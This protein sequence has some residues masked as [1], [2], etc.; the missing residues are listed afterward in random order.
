MS[1][2]SRTR[3]SNTCRALGPPPPLPEGGGWGVGGVGCSARLGGDSSLRMH[4]PAAEVRG[5][6]P[7]ASVPCTPSSPSEPPPHR[8]DQPVVPPRDQDVRDLHRF[9]E[10]LPRPLD[11]HRPVQHHAVLQVL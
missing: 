9:A 2:C 7:A 5:H 1:A 8:I 4:F 10:T 3:I 11:I 6:P